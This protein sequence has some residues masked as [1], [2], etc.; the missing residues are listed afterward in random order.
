MLSLSS[1]QCQAIN[2]IKYGYGFL[3]I[4]NSQFFVFGAAPASPYN[5]QIYK[6]TFLSTSVNWAKKVACPSGVWGSDDSESMMSY[7]GSTIYSFFLFGV[8]RYLYFA[9]LAV[10]DGSILTTRY[11]SSISISYLQGS[12]MNGDY[13]VL[14]TQNSFLMIYSISTSTFTIMSFSSGNFLYGWAVEPSSGR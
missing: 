4:S 8:T 7:D 2:N 13:V 11:K 10:S 3:M 14:T 5:L 1:A 9:G 12:A 6:I